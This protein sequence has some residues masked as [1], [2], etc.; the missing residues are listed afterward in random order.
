MLTMTSART[1]TLDPA[2][3]QALDS[4]TTL[5]GK[6]REIGKRLGTDHELATSLWREA[7]SNSKLVAVLAMDRKQLTPDYLEGLLADLE[8]LDRAEQG[9]VGEWLLANAL[10]AA[11][12]LH[13][14]MDAWLESPSLMR[15]RL[16]W[17]FKARLMRQ[18]KSST[19]EAERLL[20]LIERDLGAA[21]PDLQWVMNYCAAMIGI[22]DP[23]RRQRCLDLGER[24]GLYLDYP[25]PK[26]C[27]S[28]YLPEW[29][30]SQV[31]KAS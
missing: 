4:P 3:R 21:D 9:K 11:K 7:N 29:I 14:T 24:L 17:S 15:R 25:V 19:A 26:G 1:M 20:R 31:A 30:G 13:P 23:E 22:Y 18:Q 12:K 6:L 10:M 2:V 27:T 8:A 5:M 16:F 28:P